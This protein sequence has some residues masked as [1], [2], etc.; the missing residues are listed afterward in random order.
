MLTHFRG[1]PIRSATKH[2]PKKELKY[3]L[4]LRKTQVG[5][6][7]SAVKTIA[8]PLFLLPTWNLLLY[9]LQ[10]LFG[11]ILAYYRFC[12]GLLWV[13]L[14]FCFWTKHQIGANILPNVKQTNQVMDNILQFCISLVHS[15]FWMFVI[16]W[17]CKLKRHAK[18]ISRF[19]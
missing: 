17:K 19:F 4:Q 6:K 1:A 5:K 10:I 16:H 13:Y 18:M 14:G 9:K 12:I 8:P 3:L 7:W 15:K 2:T 11:K